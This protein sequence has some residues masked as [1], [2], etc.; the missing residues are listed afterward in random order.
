MRIHC[1]LF[2]A[3]LFLASPALAADRCAAVNVKSTTISR[4][5]DAALI[6]AKDRGILTRASKRNLGPRNIDRVM[7]DGAW[8]LV[9]V[10][11]KDAESSVYFFRRGAKRGFNL[12]DT[13]GG[14]M[15]PDDRQGGINWARK[16]KGG[17]T[18]ARLAACFADAMIAG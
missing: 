1:S 18:S 9:W 12:V 15:A 7:A 10:S 13:W 14:V 2:L 6:R 3:A 16:L 17:G 4:T 5:A 11:T 8:R